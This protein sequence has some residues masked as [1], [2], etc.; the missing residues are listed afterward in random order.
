MNRKWREWLFPKVAWGVVIII[1]I[2]IV[3][4]L[5]PKQYSFV[6]QQVGYKTKQAIQ[7]VTNNAYKEQYP[8][9]S[10]IIYGGDRGMLGVQNWMAS[11]VN[12]ELLLVNYY[13]IGAQGDY[14]PD[15]GGDPAYEEYQ[16]NKIL[17]PTPAETG[18]EVETV[19]E[20]IEPPTEPQSQGEEVGAPVVTLIKPEAN[21][22]PKIVNLPSVGGLTLDQMKDFDTLINELY[23]IHPGCS[24][25]PNEL[26]PTTL[27]SKNLKI[28]GDNSQ[29]QILIYHTHSQEGY[30]DSVPG[31]VS[32]T[33]VGVGDYLTELLTNTYGYNVIH[34][35]GIYDMTDGE[36]DRDPAYSKALPEITKIIEENPSIEIV[37]DL[38]RDGV[39]EDV[40]LVTEIDGKQTARLMFFNGV[41]RD[42]NGEIPGLENPYR[43]DNLA[44]SLQMALTAEAYY[45]DLMRVIYLKQMRY[46]EHLMSRCAL[47]E[48]GAQT[49]TVEEAMN[50][51]PVLADILHKVL[52]E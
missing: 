3:S 38:H 11:I 33:I 6:K 46:N 17:T 31:D 52:S 23:V 41:C 26:N 34:H 12:S 35:K 10:Y 5:F 24:I 27:L 4:L 8:L 9:A 51:M 50:T 14:L 7:I 13:K 25:T 39:K 48:V 40:H 49:N 18:T 28:K 29:P 2:Y 37:I 42:T 20:E 43:E 45:P 36:L 32:Q 30:A 47:V 19:A 22:I 44:F 1:G 16:N 21:I 15:T